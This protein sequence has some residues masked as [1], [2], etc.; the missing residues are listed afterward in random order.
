[1]YP[2][3]LKFCEFIP[4]KYELNWHVRMDIRRGFPLSSNKTNYSGHLCEDNA[5]Y[6]KTIRSELTEIQPIH[7]HLGIKSI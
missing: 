3:K 6:L 1:M 4:H 5:I 2:K 7:G